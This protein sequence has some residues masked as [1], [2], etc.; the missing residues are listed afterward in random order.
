M[1][2]LE[3]KVEADHVLSLKDFS[4]LIYHFDFQFISLMDKFVSLLYERLKAHLIEFIVLF[5]L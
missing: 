1:V 2:T 3:F 5:H 4:Y